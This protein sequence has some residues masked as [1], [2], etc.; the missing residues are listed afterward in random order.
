MAQTITVRNLSEATQK[1]LRH[2]AVDHGRSLE[3]EIRQILDDTVREAD[4]RPT[5]AEE[6]LLA[7]RQFRQSAQ[8]AGVQFEI[9]PR[10]AEEQRQVFA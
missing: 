7:A 3:A 10:N 2:R 6:I 8:A 1:A 9:P 4:P 5:A